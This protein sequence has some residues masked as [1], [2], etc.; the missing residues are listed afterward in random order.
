MS[1]FMD[2]R[3]TSVMALLVALLLLSGCATTPLGRTQFAMLPDSQMAQMGNQAFVNIKGK[4]PLDRDLRA[5]AYVECV[6]GAIVKETGGQWEVAVFR[7]ATPNAFALPGGKIG[8]N[9][10]IFAVAT[11]QDQLATVLA[12]EVAH[13]L[14]RHTNERVS[15]QLALSQGLNV[16]QAIASPTSATGQSLMGLLGVGAQYGILLPYNRLQES[17]AD[18]LGLDLMAK[19]GFDPRQS[20]GLWRNMDRASGGAQPVEFLSTHPSHGTRMKDLEARIPSAMGLMQQAQ[21]NGKRPQ[22]DSLR[23]H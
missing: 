21:A 2:S 22:C 18:L 7:D 11:N 3:M 23:G 9:S 8:V 19:A 1:Q 15:Q 4:T 13:V 20:L 6:A 5:N 12:H 10:G 14:A 16:L 17:E